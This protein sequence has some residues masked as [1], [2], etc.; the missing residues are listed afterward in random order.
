[1]KYAYDPPTPTSGSSPFQVR[2]LLTK[3]LLDGGGSLLDQT[4]YVYENPYYSDFLTGVIDGRGVR[5]STI[6]Y[7][8]NGNGD[9]VLIAHLP[10]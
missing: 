6:A 4:S 7:D 10:T 8:L 2:R 5:Y 9:S 3:Q 1:L